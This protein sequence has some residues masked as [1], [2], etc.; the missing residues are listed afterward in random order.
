[1]PEL[2][3]ILAPYL[4]ENSLPEGEAFYAVSLAGLEALAAERGGGLKQAMLECLEQGI[5]PERFRANRGELSAQDQA[6]LLNSSVAVMGCGGLGGLACLLLARLGVGELLLVDGDSFEESNL[7]R[8]MLATPE[9]LGRPKAQVAAQAAASLNPACEA[10]GEVAWIGP[11]NLPALVAGRQVV[12]D[13]LDNLT[14]RYHLEDAC[15][16][17]GVPL[18]HGALAGMEGM[19]MVI[20]PQGPGLRELHGPTP[21]PK[22]HGAEV[23]LGTPTPT[24][25]A[26]ASLQVSEAMKLLLGRKGL[27]PG[28]LLHLDLG[29]PALEILT[30]G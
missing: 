4:Q 3:R 21:P 15:R 18:V 6:R 23:L 30:L 7:N 27:G 10:R 12:V 16:A 2:R 11:E 25:A 9:T 13:C 8:Q 29:A 20:P 5:W 19:V 17:A 26:V 28:K 14:A 1:M 24:P 22:E